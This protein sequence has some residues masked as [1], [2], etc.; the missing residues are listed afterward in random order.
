MHAEPAPQPNHAFTNLDAAGAT[1]AGGAPDGSLRLVAESGGGTALPAR[2]RRVLVV[3]DEAIVQLHLARIVESLGH[4]VVGPVA[5]GEAAL[6]AAA[7]LVPDVAVLDVRLASMMDGIETARLLRER[8]GCAVVFVTA[9]ADEQTV[10]RIESAEASGY[11]VKPFRQ[12]EIRIAL[13]AALRERATPRPVAPEPPVVRRPRSNTRVL[14]YSH[15]TLGLGHLQRSLN[16]ARA[17]L[18]NNS[19]MSV[20]LATGS[21]VAHRFPLPEGSDTM[22]LPAVRKV[23]AEDYAARSLDL[24]GDEILRLRS[25]LLLRTV[26]DYEPDALIVDHAPTGMRG[27]MLPAL[28]WLTEN[29]K[30]VKML[31]LRDIID[32]PA[33]ITTTW[34]RDGVYD[35]I[36]TY[37]DHVNIYG[38]QNLFDVATAY[39]FPARLAAKTHFVGYVTGEDASEET[40]QDPVFENRT[41]P[42]VVVTIGGGDGGANTV[43]GNYL[44]MLRRHRD[45]IDFD[46]VILTGPLLPAATLTQ[47]REQA[48]GLPVT[49]RDFV[50]SARPYIRRADL[51]VCT[52]GYNTMTEVLSLAPRA[53]VIPRILHRQE[54][55]MRASRFAALGFVDVLHPDE[56][57]A[58]TMYER[59][60][61]QLNDAHRPIAAAREI[62]TLHFDGAERVARICETAARNALAESGGSA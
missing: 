45:R 41:R 57:N 17:L 43:I 52:A 14:L 54:Q 60:S 6:A 44:E 38:M 37:Y 31:G 22:K 46:S 62:R 26:R 12:A 53:L 56:A 2:A 35:A 23:A 16:L 25:N 39:G 40:T 51:V 7:Q 3:E 42:L 10:S 28:Q 34:T 27:E 9:Y 59:V 24:S 30:C 8:H 47:L 58:D 11:V 49:L 4:Q 21:P 48:E 1:A 5:S 15:D 13:G 18:A 32:D 61:R 29:T 33:Y 19:K 50:A 20:L 36:D 55:I